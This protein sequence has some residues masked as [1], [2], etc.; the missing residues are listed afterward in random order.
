MENKRQTAYK[1]NILQISRGEYIQM[2]GWEPNYVLVNKLKVSRVNIIGVVLNKTESSLIIDDGSAQISLR[3]FDDIK[4]IDKF[5]AGDIIL[6]IGRPREYNDERYIV[7][8]IIKKIDKK[9][10]DYRKKE[11]QKQ[12]ISPQQETSKPAEITMEEAPVVPKNKPVNILSVIRELDEGD[13]VPTEVLIQKINSED[14]QTQINQLINEGEIFE[15]RPGK[16]KIL[17]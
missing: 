17:E 7:P 12:V 5:S 4:L 14:A 16:I 1:C 2:Q 8:E 10:L 9:W 15:I 6:S 11:L 13:G 3:V